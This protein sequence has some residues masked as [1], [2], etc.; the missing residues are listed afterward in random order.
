MTTNHEQN[1]I[2]RIVGGIGAIK[3]KEKTA[4]EANLGFLFTKLQAINLHEYEKLM[5]S[6]KAAVESFKAKA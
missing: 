5:G 4:Q 3:R 6:Y 1:L 2:N